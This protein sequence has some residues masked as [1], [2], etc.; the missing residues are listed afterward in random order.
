M[1]WILFTFILNFNWVPFLFHFQ[2]SWRASLQKEKIVSFY[3]HVDI[4]ME[5]FCFHIFCGINI[6]LELDDAKWEWRWQLL[7]WNHCKRKNEKKCEV[8]SCY[9]N[10]KNEGLNEYEMD[11]IVCFKKCQIQIRGKLRWMKWTIVKRFWSHTTMLNL[12]EYV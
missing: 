6:Y 8:K 10:F 3:L 9:K 5:W 1:I 2:L 11:I 7:I 4:L 12:Y